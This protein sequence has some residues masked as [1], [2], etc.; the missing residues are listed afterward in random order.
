MLGR[1]R[2]NDTN[3]SVLTFSFFIK[4]LVAFRFYSFSVFL[5]FFGY[6][7]GK[8]RRKNPSRCPKRDTSRP[9]IINSIKGDCN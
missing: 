5:S 8:R 6:K 3:S 1:A 4:L 9:G 7:R 2:D